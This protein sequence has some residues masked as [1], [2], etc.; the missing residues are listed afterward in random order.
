MSVTILGVFDTY[1]HANEFTQKLIQS[2][3]DRSAITTTPDKQPAGDRHLADEDQ[4][5]WSG[6]K[7]LFTGD[8]EQEAGYYAEATRRGG[9]M[10][11]AVVPDDR[12][13]EV[14]RL[15][16]QYHAIDVHGRAEQ[17]KQKG[18]TGYEAAAKPLAGSE[19]KAARDEDQLIPVVEE[20]LTVGKRAVKSGGIRVLRTVTSRD[21]S[22]D[23]KLHK[24]H[25]GVERHAVD[26]QLT[27]DEADAAFTNKTI[28]L[29]ETNEEAVVGKS[30]RVVEEVQINKDSDDTTE[31]V[32]GTV[33]K[34]D[35][36]VEKVPGETTA[37]TPSR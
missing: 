15:M 20:Q 30:A 21:V 6:L 29:S 9:T 22:E 28:E 3:I 36:K 2:G 1:N 19:L 34:T 32:H 4:G 35:V 37:T 5:F 13:D 23:V 8:D 25:V 26:R 11:S 14:T 18:W 17:W 31:T 16:K 24:E 10:V 27:G 7:E 12:S 33:R